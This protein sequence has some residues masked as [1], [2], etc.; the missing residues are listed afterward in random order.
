MFLYN[1]VNDDDFMI[2]NTEGDDWSPKSDT[3]DAFACLDDGKHSL[4]S[5]MNYEQDHEHDVESVK[6]ESTDDEISE[7][8]DD[9]QK[10]FPLSLAAAH[11]VCIKLDSQIQTG[12][13]T[14]TSDGGVKSV[15]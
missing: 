5:I 11:D 3:E 13:L 8:E 2:M 15:R 9:D 12:V 1:S 4:D 7:P 6:E 10:I 14:G